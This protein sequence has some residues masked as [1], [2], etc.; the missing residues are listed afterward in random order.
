MSAKC[1]F[2]LVSLLFV[3]KILFAQTTVVRLYDLPDSEGAKLELGVGDYDLT[4]D[5]YKS[6][7]DMCSSISILPGYQVTVFTEGQFS[8]DQRIF[9]QTMP[10]LDSRWDNKISGVKIVKIQQTDPVVLYDQANYQGSSLALEAGDYDLTSNAYKSFNDVPSSI[11]IAPGYQVMVFSDG[12]FS[13]NQQVFSQSVVSLDSK[14]NN[15]ISGIK[16]TKK[17]VGPCNGKTPA[18]FYP[19]FGGESTFSD[20]F[21]Q[22]LQTAFDARALIN[23]GNDAAAEAKLN[24]MWAKLPPSD[25]GWNDLKHESDAKQI[26]LGSP[27]MYASMRMLTDYINVR[28]EIQNAGIQPREIVLQFVLVGKSSGKKPCSVDEL[29]NGGGTDKINNL[30][31]DLFKY[32]FQMLK[33]SV[34]IFALYIQAVSQGNLKLKVE[35]YPLQY[36]TIPTVYTKSGNPNENK[37]AVGIDGSAMQ[38]IDKV[39][40]RIKNKTDWWCVVYPS[41]QFAAS[42]SGCAVDNYELTTTGGIETVKDDVPVF[43]VDDRFITHK[44]MA[45]GG[46]PYSNLERIFGLPQFYQ[47]EFF[48]YLFKLY[49]DLHL[50]DQPHSYWYPKNWPKDSKGKYRFGLDPNSLHV[51]DF[52]PDIID[53]EPDIYH[54]FLTKILYNQTPSLSAR[55]RHRD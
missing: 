55:L 37:Y 40:E 30:D 42:P 33:E 5:V 24:A 2:S 18:G 38:I 49:P 54:E 43:V 12:Q 46:E 35:I 4:S 28:K 29:L 27:P 22:A 50:E 44:P 20:H 9:T 36:D 3:T 26:A 21:K 11:S 48:H 32:N 23:A 25:K 15:Q 14:W 17:T 41:R 51:A 13:G 47:H 31:L 52:N 53:Y 34:D 8:G 7:N 10:W 16:I 19:C 39:P 1:G 6:F 45:Q